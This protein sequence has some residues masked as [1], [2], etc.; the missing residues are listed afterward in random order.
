M[1]KNLY[2]ILLSLRVNNLYMQNNILWVLAAV[3]ILGGGFLLWQ[4]M[5]QAPVDVGG[6]STVVDAST[7]GTGS[8]GS[9]SDAPMIGAVTYN[10]DDGFFPAEVTIKKGGSVSW[11]NSSDGTMWIASGPHPAHTGYSNTALTAHCPD[12]AGTAFDQ[13][14]N[15]ATYTFKFDKV[16]TW[17]YHNHSASTKFGRVIV[18]E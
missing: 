14:A 16:G 12:T 1:A 5:A 13:C 3:V 8:D 4:N 17:P 10:T 15:G 2:D 6:S 7:D 9:G 11:T 18:V